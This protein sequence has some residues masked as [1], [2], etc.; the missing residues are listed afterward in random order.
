MVFR[1]SFGCLVAVLL[2]LTAVSA[3]PQ[4]YG[5]DVNTRYDTQPDPFSTYGSSSTPAGSFGG[6]SSDPFNRD[7]PFGNNNNNN[8]PTNDPFLQQSGGRFG[9]GDQSNRFGGSGVDL[10]GRFGS[11]S[12]DT[13][14]RFGDQ[15]NNRF[16]DPTNRNRFDT[17]PNRSPF[18]S[19]VNHHRGRNSFLETTANNPLHEPTYFVVASRM[20]RPGQVYRVAVQVISTPQPISVRASIARDGVEMSGDVKEVKEGVPETLLMRVPPTSVVGNYKLR[21]EGVYSHAFGGIAFVN[22]TK[23]TFSQRSMTIFVQTDKPTYMQGETVRFRTIPI[24]TA[25]RGFDSAIDVYMKDPNGHVLRRWL[26]RQS[27]LGTVSLDYKLSDQPVYGEW[28]IQVVAQGQVEEH[29]FMVE[30]YYQTR[31]EVNVTMPAFFF[32]TDAFIYGRVMA[33]FTSGA[34][35]RG[36]LTIKATIRPIGWFNTRVLN[37]RNRVG[38]TGARNLPDYHI[39]EEYLN[40]PLLS[41]NLNYGVQQDPNY[42]SD[43]RFAQS[44][45]LIG[46][47]A[48]GGGYQDQYTHERHFNFDEE[49]PFWVRKPDSTQAWDPWTK[50]YTNALP[51]LRFFNGTYEFRYPMAELAALLPSQQGME[52]LVTAT[53]G[54]KFYDEVIS[55]YSIARVYNSSIKVSFLGGTPQ[56]FKPT[57]P[58]VCYIVAEY[59]DGSPI[60]FNDFYQARLEINGFVES[61]TG[62]R[63]DYPLRLLKMSE[64][65]GIWEL[66]I[67]LRN[68]LNLDESPAGREYLSEVNQMRVT[69]NYMDDRGERNTAELL[70]LS[71]HSPAN[72]HIK[73]STSTAHAKVGEYVILHVQTNFFTESF[74][75]MLMSKGVVLLTGQEAM[76]EGIRTMAITLSA[77]MAPVSTIVVWHIAQHGL[78]VADSLTFPVNGIS[79]NNF[80]VHIN[81][82]KARTGERVEVAVYGE[83]GAY[84]GLSGIDNAFY[85]MQAG[86]ELTYAKVTCFFLV[87]YCCLIL[88]E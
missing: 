84:V 70:L 20:V 23:L 43:P 87:F 49:W 81:N 11:G 62:G 48:Q 44:G 3:Q 75:Y 28:T 58:F 15:S 12:S 54:D 39:N 6:V 32:N 68:E 55:G 71:H 82:R 59:H 30:E 66:K 85:T 86:N 10:T 22:E 35:V 14:G 56:V 37:Q 21:V 45:P 34:P 4:E 42:A 88:S 80:T 72:R 73:V 29:K 26:S 31:F 78:I 74:N 52:V 65:N 9:G 17:S 24:T 13:A 53:V 33:N 77:E 61:R 57:M 64:K 41:P 69:V 50:T 8:N 63:R 79:R 51:Y 1:P 40:N 36:N 67:D 7:Q 38:N 18:E 19:N 46:V 47:G 16:G 60:P 25:L 2:L 27:N 83:P 76:K 5:N